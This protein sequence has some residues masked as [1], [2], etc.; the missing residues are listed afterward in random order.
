M[1]EAT[2]G[3]IHSVINKFI[4]KTTLFLPY[5]H[6]SSVSYVFSDP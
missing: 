5:F 1:R 2:C 6:G 3:L 4:H